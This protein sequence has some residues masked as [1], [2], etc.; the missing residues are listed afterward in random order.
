SNPLLR[1]IQEWQSPDF[2]DPVNLLFALSLV[3]LAIV[4]IANRLPSVA[5]IGDRGSGIGDR[6]AGRPDPRS[7]IPDPRID[8]TDALV[9]ALFTLMALQVTRLLPVYGV[10]VL[11]LL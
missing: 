9:L 10:M 6:S 5:G 8:A 1:Y 2:H 7:P 3:L 4:G 11:P